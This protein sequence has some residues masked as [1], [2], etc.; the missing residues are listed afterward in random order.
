MKSALTGTQ[1]QLTVSLGRVWGTLVE[2]FEHRFD[3]FTIE[4]KELNERNARLL[5]SL[6]VGALA[7][8]MAFLSLNALLIVAFWENRILVVAS[9]SAFY[10]VAGAAVLWRTLAR[11]RAAAPPFEATVGELRRD[12]ESWRTEQ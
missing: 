6:Q 3:L 7:L 11:I 2:G 10:A 12:Y 8:F 4:L 1:E 9:I 5:L